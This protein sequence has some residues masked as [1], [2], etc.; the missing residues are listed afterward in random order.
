MELAGTRLLG[1]A[2]DPLRVAQVLPPGD[3][4]DV[5]TQ[6]LAGNCVGDDID[7]DA[8]ARQIQRLRR[9]AWF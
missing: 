2:S 1:H 4:T 3:R 5:S 6:L 8:S 7:A 9:R